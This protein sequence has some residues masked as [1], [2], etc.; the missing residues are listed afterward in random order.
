MIF[1]VS[2]NK[3]KDRKKFEEKYEI[4]RKDILVG[5]TSN[6]GGFCAWQ[7]LR[8]PHLDVVYYMG[9]MGYGDPKIIIKECKKS[10]INIKFLSWFPINDRGKTI[11]WEKEYGRW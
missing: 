6:S 9:F 3:P 8:N 4:K 11:C 1:D 5:E 10:K 2:F 7:I